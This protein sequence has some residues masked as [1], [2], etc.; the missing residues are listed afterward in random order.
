VS[1]EDTPSVF[2][3][4]TELSND[5][6][7]S[8]ASVGGINHLDGKNLPSKG[9]ITRITGTL[10][11]LL[12]PGFFEG[13]SLHSS[14]LRIE[15]ASLMDAVVGDL[16]DEIYKSL[17]Y[18][19][20]PSLEGEH[21]RAASRRLT[22]EFLGNLPAIREKLQG[23]TEAAFEGDPAAKSSEE[24]IV[25]YP[26]IEAIAVQRMA[27]ALYKSDIVLIPRIMTE[28]AHA[29]TGM[30]LHPGA[31]IGS[32]FFIDHGTGT[33]IG[34]TCQI[35]NRV[36][37]YHGVTLGARSTSQVEKLRGVKRHPTIEDNVTIYPGATI[38]GGDTTIGKGSTIGGNVFL[39]QSVPPNSLVLADDVKV[40]VKT[41]KD[42]S[43]RAE[44]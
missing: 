32:H 37:L 24:I 36:K 35:G 17:A 14:E 34:E 4:V 38:L 13:Q 11:Q 7:A 23:D 15:T 44:A 18:H 8:Y 28:W 9:A 40:S 41:K 30:D 43:S 19:L 22:L 39:M 16:E 20:P 21:P 29:Q 25:A 1:A 31:A 5:L 10:L 33:V 27:H 3:S 42:R 12:F 6:V 26:F 2:K